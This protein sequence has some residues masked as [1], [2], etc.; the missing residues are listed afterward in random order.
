ME[1]RPVVAE[2][3]HFVASRH[4]R[5]RDVVIDG[6]CQTHRIADADAREV[7]LVTHNA[8]VRIQDVNV[9]KVHS[10]IHV[11]HHEVNRVVNVDDFLDREFTTVVHSGAVGMFVG[12]VEP[13]A[14]RHQ[15]GIAHG[16]VAILVDVRAARSGQV[17]AENAFHVSDGIRI[18]LGIVVVE[19]TH[20]R[21]ASALA[22]A[23]HLGRAKEHPVA[24]VN[25][26]TASH[27]FHHQR[28]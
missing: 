28:P 6:I 3:N 14:L 13:L 21:S 9:E 8:V 24:I 15:R 4:K 17:V 7:E 25:G 22:I 20:K 26:F 16:D 23:V 2:A 10:P 18:L 11:G 19:V 1:R 27:V 5:R 12:F